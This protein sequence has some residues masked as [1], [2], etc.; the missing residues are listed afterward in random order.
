MRIICFISFSDFMGNLPYVTARRPTTSSIWCR[1]EGFCN[2]Y[3]YPVSWMWTTVLMYFL[4]ELATK[5]KV[6]L[7]ELAV[8]TLCWGLPLI[9]ALLVLT[10][11]IYGRFDLND[12]NEVCTIGGDEVSAF[13]WHVIIYYGLFCVCDIVMFCLFYHVI[14]M[15]TEVQSTVSFSMLELAIESL[16]LYPVAM[17]VSWLPE[18]I[19]FIVQFVHHSDLAVHISVILKLSNGILLTIIFFYKSQHAR[20]LWIRLI[21][22]KEFQ[23]FR[24]YSQDS[25]CCFDIMEEF[26]PE[27]ERK[28]SLLSDAPIVLHHQSS[29]ITRASRQISLDFR[30][31]SNTVP[32]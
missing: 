25:S 13:V 30:E 14:K 28:I 22:G 23:N 1:L 20:I 3:F 5:G 15:K 10:T 29:E 21:T 18:F 24:E 12:D 19:V 9:S 16:Q 17:T 31:T 32:Y 27:F 26:S 4:Y 8:N 7:S 11:N 2:L 6:S